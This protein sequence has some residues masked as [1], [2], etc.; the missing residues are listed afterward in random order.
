MGLAELLCVSPDAARLG[1]RVGYAIFSGPPAER[2]LEG[3][4]SI[5][6]D[7]VGL[8]RAKYSLDS[9]KN[10]PRV[11]AYRKFYWRI[12]IDPTKTRPS[13]EA[14]VRRALRGKWPRIS[15][16]VDAGNIAS[17]L[18]MIPIGLYDMDSFSPPACIRIS[19]GGEVFHAIG[20]KD[21]TVPEGVPIMVDG[22]GIVMHL[23]PHR[24]SRITMVRP[25][26]TRILA[27][28]AGVPG[29]PVEDLKGVLYKLEELLSLLSWKRVGPVRLAP[30]EATG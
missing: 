13:S 6:D 12:G 4:D 15:P 10:D 21:E 1:V 17:A 11:S 7:M 29:V 16:I 20:G 22:R 27:V 24:D 3:W 25:S 26:T 18:Y 23:Y 30:E 14:L 8:L 9:L 2:Y 19:G 5:V 28:S